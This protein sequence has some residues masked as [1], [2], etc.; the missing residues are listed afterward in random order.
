MRAAQGGRGLAPW[1]WGCVGSPC[2][3]TWGMARYRRRVS[4]IVCPS[5]LEAE[6]EQTRAPPLS[7]KVWPCGTWAI[8]VTSTDTSLW[9]AHAPRTHRVREGH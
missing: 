8:N 5:A 4:L 1:S 9:D 3:S 7:T 6:G 2:V